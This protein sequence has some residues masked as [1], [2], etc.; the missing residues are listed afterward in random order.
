MVSGSA[1]YMMTRDE[2][3]SNKYNDFKFR[4]ANNGWITKINGNDV[5]FHFHPKE[6]ENVSVSDD[7]IEKLDTAQAYLTFEIG[8][9][10]Q[11][12]RINIS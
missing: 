8:K 1:G 2:S 9:N 11:N 3:S 6:I 7:V 12:W 10:L 5:M 4:Y